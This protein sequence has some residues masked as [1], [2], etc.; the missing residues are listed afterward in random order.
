MVVQPILRLISKVSQLLARLLIAVRLTGG[1]CYTRFWSRLCPGFQ[2]D[3][4]YVR[5][6]KPLFT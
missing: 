1:S 5:H 3:M 6:L 2:G 4:K